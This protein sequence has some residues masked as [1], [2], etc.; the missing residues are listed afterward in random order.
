MIVKRIRGT[1]RIFH[2]RL[3][4][5]RIDIEHEFGS[6]SNLFKRINQKHTWHI[7]SLKKTIDYHYF[8]IYLM[9]NI[10]TCV[11]ENKTSAKYGVPSPSVDEYLGVSRQDCYDGNDADQNMIQ[12]LRL[13]N[14]W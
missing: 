1:Q 7:M 4:K 6:I 12:L 8:S 5:S 13:Q 10:Y 3:T 2:A 9:M 14:N 11:R